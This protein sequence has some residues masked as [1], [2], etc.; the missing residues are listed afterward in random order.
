MELSVQ[1]HGLSTAK[2]PVR[3]EI[4][5]ARYPIALAPSI[6]AWWVA[7]RELAEDL[8]SIAKLRQRGCPPVPVRSRWGNPTMPPHHVKVPGP[9]GWRWRGW[10]WEAGRP[11]GL[12]SGSGSGDCQTRG[13]CIM[14]WTQRA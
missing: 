6:T 12:V 7:Y 8:L 1:G 14:P 9:R 13:P 11:Q 2:S 4:P 3:G 10:R 5:H